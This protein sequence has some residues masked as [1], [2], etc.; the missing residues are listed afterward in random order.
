MKEHG[1]DFKSV[2]LLQSCMRLVKDEPDSGSEEW[3]TTFDDGT[4]DGNIKVEEADIKVE[5]SNIEVAESDIEFE[6]ADIKIEDAIDV[7]KENP[8]AILIPPIT[9]EPEVSVWGLFLRQLQ[10]MFPRSFTVTK[11][12]LLKL[13]FN[14]LYVCTMH[15]V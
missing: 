6:E 1:H 10:F 12:E 9:S 5:V 3:V 14:C 11:R 15:F 2:V 4:E 13:H 7:K 8:E